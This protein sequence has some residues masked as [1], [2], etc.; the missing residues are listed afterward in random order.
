MFN[1][2]FHSVFLTEGDDISIPTTP[3][4]EET[5]SDI[6][7]D[8]SEV[9][10]VLHCL[11]PSKASGPDNI[12]IRLLKECAH[13]ITPS[14]T[15]LF[16]KSLKHASLPSEW[17]LS[18]I[19]PLHKKGIKSFVENYRPISL[20]CVV[21]KVLERCVYNRLIGHIENMIS[22]AQHG[23]LRG[24]SCTGQLISVLHRISQ[25]LDSGKQTDILYF[26]VA[27]AFDTVNHSLLL[28]KLQRFGLR[29][30][31]L[32]WFKSYLSGRQQ[33]VLVNGEISETCPVSSGVPQGSILGPL[34]F[35]IYIND[36]PESITSSAVDVSL[37]ADDTKCIS[38]IESPV[39]AC[40]LQAEARNVEKWAEF[41]RLKFNA[42]KCKVLSVTRKRHPLVAE[43][44]VNERPRSDG[45]FRSQMEHSYLRASYES[46]PP[47]WYAQT[48]DYQS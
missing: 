31:I 42:E 10:D 20:M 44:I 1:D 48:F 8:P 27:K 29:D 18:N 33:R 35:L 32:T 45:L 34:L 47:T 12:P 39:D 14:L 24:K 41:W 4:C 43:Y 2:Y 25:N 11:D 26:D 30:N 21:A 7:L 9:Y 5:I 17:K 28:K 38:V 40:V 23:F 3:V 22:V 13:S 37:F 46:Q 6:I 16:N 19:I 36:L 15:C